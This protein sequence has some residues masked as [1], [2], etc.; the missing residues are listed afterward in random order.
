MSTSYAGPA[1]RSPA[2]RRA[3]FSSDPQQ[4][5]DLFLPLAQPAVIGA[6]NAPHLNIELELRGKIGQAI[7]EAR[8][9]GYGRERIVE[10]MN[11]ALPDQD[12]DITLR[13]LNC[14]TAE[15][16]QYH[17]FPLRYLAAFCWATGSDAPLRMVSHA[18]GFDLVDAR[19][20]AAKRLGDAHIEIAR[21]RRE[22]GALTRTL[23]G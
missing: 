17:P 2:K 6:P 5:H 15:S 23:G 19:E 1:H 10:R 22:A 18:L 11:L 14:W 4:Q 7:R 9:L 13:Q 12:R 20:A 3:K 21:L 16:K 8:S